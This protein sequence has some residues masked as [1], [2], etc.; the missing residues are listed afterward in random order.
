MLQV[1]CEVVLQSVCAVVD[2]V[3]PATL[4]EFVSYCLWQERKFY[5][6]PGHCN[7]LFVVVKK[8]VLEVLE[9]LL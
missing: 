7:R 5:V 8:I 9:G 2:T 3:V 1:V 6:I 4:E